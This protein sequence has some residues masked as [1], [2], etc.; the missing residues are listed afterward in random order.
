MGIRNRYKKTLLAAAIGAALATSAGMPTVVWAQT[1]DATLRGRTA[2]NSEVVAR[3]IATGVTRRTKAGADG[4]YYLPGLQPGTYRV[5]AGPGTETTVTLTVD[6]TAT[7][8]L[9]PAAAV[10]TAPLEEVTV[11]SQRL[12]EVKTSEIGGTVSLQ[13]IETVPQITRNFLEFADTIPGM[14][15][16]VNDQHQSSLQSG[17]QNASAVNEIG[18]AHV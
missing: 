4:S 13:T 14:V 2:A 11:R 1:A 7:L 3:N 15:F 18:R 12:Y 17:G 8:D 9:V 10:S 16:S 6:S 5:E